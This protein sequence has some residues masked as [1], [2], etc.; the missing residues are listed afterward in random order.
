MVVIFEIVIVIGLLLIIV[1]DSLIMGVDQV[2]CMV[3]FICDLMQGWFNIGDL[4]QVFFIGEF[5]LIGYVWDVW[6]GYCKD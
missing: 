3:F 4:V 6:L 2:V 5:V 1:M